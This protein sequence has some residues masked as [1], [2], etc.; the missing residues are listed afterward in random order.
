M[1]ASHSSW[2]SLAS[3]APPGRPPRPVDRT[4]PARA[5]TH[6]SAVLCARFARL[7]TSWLVGKPSLLAVRQVR[8]RMFAKNHSC[9]HETTQVW[10]GDSKGRDYS[11]HAKECP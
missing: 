4:R 8:S 2:E 3:P 10:Q 7:K 5:R 11:R 9:S 6:Y 1:A